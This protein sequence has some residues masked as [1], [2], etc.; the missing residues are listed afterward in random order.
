MTKKTSRV[1]ALLAGASLVIAA[2]GGDDGDSSSSDTGAPATEA[3]SDGGDTDTS[4]CGSGT[5]EGGAGGAEG[6]AAM[7]ITIDINPD[8]VWQDGCPVTVADFQCSV[9]ATLNTPG[10]IDTTGYDKIISVEAG[11]SDQQVV[12]EFNAVY[13]PYKLLF[14]SLIQATAVEDCNDVS[15]DFADSIQISGREWIMDSWSP[16]QLVF[17]PN[18]NYWGDAPSTERVV[19]VPFADFDTQSAAILAGEVDFIYPQFFAGITDALSDANITNKVEFGGDFEGFYFQSDPNRGGPFSDPIFR[20]AFVKS[21]D[22]QGVFEQ[23]YIPLSDGQGKLLECGPI[24]PGPYCNDSFVGQYDPE[25]AVAL[26]EANGWAKDGSGYWAKDGGEAPTIRWIINTGNTR[27]ENTQAYLIPLMQA[28]GFNVVADNCDAA[29]YFQQRLPA[30]DYD[31]AMYISTAPPDPSYLNASFACDQIPSDANN[32]AGQNSTGWCNEEATA[33]LKEADITVDEGPRAE[34]VKQVMD[35]MAGDYVM[36]P[37]FQFP[38]AGFWRTDRLGGPVDAQLNNYRAFN[39]FS[40]WEDVD[41]DGQII[42]GAE[43]WPE[44]LNPVTE[45]ANSSWMVWTTAFPVLPNVW[46]TT[47]GGT[48]E[49]TNLV[50][51]E[52]TVEVL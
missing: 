34:L 47:N 29:C 23:I 6:D 13:A 52:P 1:L 41:G 12:V 33:L 39:N 50:A 10:S 15:T 25:G 2:C 28:A 3:P 35:L 5:L 30:L 21:L 26:L 51:G 46:D 19:M 22:R 31:M 20:E 9:N 45:C 38:K 14:D 11:A 24:V 18:P 16:E 7:R 37:L 27:R 36:L 32:N 42:L 8:A 4:A 17:T 43:Q 40:Q 48:F 49:I 44:C